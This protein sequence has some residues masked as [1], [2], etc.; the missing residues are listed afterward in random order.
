MRP[1]WQLIDNHARSQKVWFRTD[2]APYAQTVD[3]IELEDLGTT[4]GTPNKATYQFTYAHRPV[5]LA[6]PG[7]ND[8]GTNQKLSCRFC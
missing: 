3:K 6:C 2:L 4:N 5:G 8:P 7:N 1:Y